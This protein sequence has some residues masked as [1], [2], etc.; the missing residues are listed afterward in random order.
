MQTVMD[1]QKNGG[2]KRRT[3]TAA[4]K[5][6]SK[7]YFCIECPK[8]ALR[9]DKTKKGYKSTSLPLY[10]SFSIGYTYVSV[11]LFMARKP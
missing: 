8:S 5:V 4:K 10:P 1:L 2:T 11:F 9:G 3:D 7:I 6:I